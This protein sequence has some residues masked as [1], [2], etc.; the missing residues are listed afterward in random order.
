MSRRISFDLSQ[1][2]TV[3]YSKIQKMIN[4]LSGDVHSTTGNIILNDLLASADLP[5]F[6]VGKTISIDGRTIKIGKKSYQA[7]E[8][9][10]VTINTEGSMAIYD[11]S[12]K[13]ICGC[14]RLNVSLKNIESFCIWARKNNIPTEIRSGKAERFF[15]YALLVITVLLCLLY[16]LTRGFL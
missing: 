4:I 14:L 11:R 7:Y 9:Q 3:R 10:K 13:K 6:S 15:Q 8:I 2:E 16:K 12:G 1:A 5:P